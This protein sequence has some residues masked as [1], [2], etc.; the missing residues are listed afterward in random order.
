MTPTSRLIPRG[1]FTRAA[2]ASTPLAKARLRAVNNPLKTPSNPLT[3][4]GLFTSKAST[5]KAPS[6]CTL[7]SNCE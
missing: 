6:Q 4:E 1:L 2:S 3:Q 5:S 7:D